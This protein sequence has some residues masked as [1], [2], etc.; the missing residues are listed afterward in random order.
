MMYQT[1]ADLREERR[2]RWLYLAFGLSLILTT[3]VCATIFY[4]MLAQ[5]QSRRL[6]GQESSF[7][8]GEVEEVPVEQLDVTKLLPNKPI[9]SQDIIFVIKQSD[10]NY[11]AF[12]GLDP[13]S[14]CKLNW[15]ATNFVD[16]CTQTRYSKTG[17]N[18]NF[19]Q[20]LAGPL[21]AQQSAQMIELP[22]Q[23]E[24]GNVYVID[25]ILRRDRR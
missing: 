25:S 12:L 23:T 11:Q 20:T 4:L 22:V 7:E 6:L 14:G 18:V 19:V 9:W 3:I 13:L 24:E 16:D 17:A 5:S 10:N 1:E 21:N 8:V 15:R 2:R